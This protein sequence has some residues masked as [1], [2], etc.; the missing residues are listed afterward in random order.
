MFVCVCVCREVGELDPPEVINSK[1]QHA[2]WGVQG[3]Q[4]VR[5]IIYYRK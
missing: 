5:T 3:Q 1:L 2:A 4:L